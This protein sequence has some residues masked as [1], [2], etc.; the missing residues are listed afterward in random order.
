MS[1]QGAYSHANFG[2]NRRTVIVVI[3]I[4][5]ALVAAILLID[6]AWWLMAG[7]AVFT[8]PALC[9][10]YT[11]RSAGV[12]LTESDLHW[13]T[14][15]RQADIRLAEIDHMRF[16]TRLDF[17]IRVSAVLAGKR[18]IRLPYEAL[19]PHLEFE[20]ALKNRNVKIERHHFSLL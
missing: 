5:V 2:R 16:D 18:R 17:S 7:L 1:A 20:T 6:A 3:L 19:P 15:S 14:G 10:I 12:T 13:F 4:Y 11:N 8:L 9:D